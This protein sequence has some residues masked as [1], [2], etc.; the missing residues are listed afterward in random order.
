M[1]M[2]LVEA[3][4]TLT[5]P[6]Q[7][8]EVGEETIRGIPTKFWKLAPPSLRAVLELSRGHGDQTFLVYEDES[9]SWAETLRHV[10]ALAA[11]L[12]NRFGI[13][14][15]D[16]VAIVNEPTSTMGP[17]S[18]SRDRTA[19][20]KPAARRKPVDVADGPATCPITRCPRS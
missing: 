8:F 11:A 2:S 9:W 20:S 5:A 6:G 12:V 13:A 18:S 17:G 10:D 4:D 15:G 1:A 7:M 14:P 19:A 16:R 3:T